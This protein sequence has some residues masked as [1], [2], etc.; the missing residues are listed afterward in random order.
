MV[1]C[2]SKRFGGANMRARPV[3]DASPLRPTGALR[4]VDDTPLERKSAFRVM[5]R[6]LLSLP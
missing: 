2:Y 5:A 1:G 4:P 3:T 6:R